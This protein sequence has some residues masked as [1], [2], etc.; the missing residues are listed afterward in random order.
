MWLVLLS[1]LW[2]SLLARPVEIAEPRSSPILLPIEVLG[3]DGTTVDRTLNISRDQSDRVRAVWLLVH[4]VRYP[5]QA[6]VQIN[7]S[8]W[9]PLRNDAVTVAEPGK[10]YGGI[11]GGFAALELTLHF[12]A[13]T[14]VAGGNVVRFR[15][16]RSDGLSSGYRVLALNF[17]ATDGGKILPPS[18]FAEDPPESWAAPLSDEASI[19]AGKELWLNA[20]LVAGSRQRGTRIQARCAD[21]HAHDGRDL[22]YFN[23]SNPSIIARSRF[24]GLTTQQGEQI[25]S[26][27]RSLPFPSP[28]RPWNPPYQPGPGLD[29]KAAGAWAAGA[30]LEWAL[31][32]DAKGL[33]YLLNAQGQ[34]PVATASRPAPMAPDF[35]ALLTRIRPDVFHPDGDLN[36][37]EVPIALQLPDW[38]QWLPRIHPK[39]AWGAAFVESE[40]AAMYDGGAGNH[41]GREPTLRAL[42][43]ATRTSD[44]DIRS[45]VPGFNRWQRA[46]RAFLGNYVKTKTVWSPE[47]AGKVYSTQLWQLM[48]TW[49]MTQEFDLEGQG[50]RLLGQSAESRVWCNTIPADTAPAATHIPNGAAGVGGSALTNEY[51]SASWYELQIILNSGNHQHRDRTPVDWVYLIGHFHALY[52]QSN[53]PEPVRLLVAVTKALQSTNPHLGPDDFSQGWRPDQGIDPRIMVSPRWEP[54]FKPFPFEVRRALTESMLAAWMDKNLQYP[55]SDYLPLPTLQHDYKPQESYN[56]I[57]GGRVWNAAAD[58]RAAGVSAEVVD[59]LRGWGR[60]YTDRAERLQYH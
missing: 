6:S 19:R 22:K 60:A 46:R 59:R 36:P 26:Y 47:L 7:S 16:N 56:D 11:G 15:F 41:D 17:V 35:R 44:A 40:F 55:I 48:K 45:V 30:G 42:L 27:I 57:S 33:P 14:V 31:D 50:R 49:E 25:A 24:H 3:E 32:D 23:F 10:S 5:D 2:L 37:R 58:F 54:V 28:G 4:G 20:P 39:D 1:Y 12:P 43:E 18:D 34:T 9:I 51:L 21:C 13:G 29:T 8:A 53:Q 52:L 38:S